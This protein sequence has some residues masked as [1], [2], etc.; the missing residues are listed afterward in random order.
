LARIDEV[1]EAMRREPA[2]VLVTGGGGFI[3]SNLAERLVELGQRV[4]VLDNFA[5]GH[6]RNVPAGVELVEGDIR[7]LETCQK[8]CEGVRYVF[9]QAALGSVP[10]S[11][12]DPLTSHQVNVDGTMNM[13]V[14]ARDARVAGF[15]YASSSSVYGDHP[16]LP[17]VE[18]VE[19]TPLSPYAVTKKV[20]EL[21]A[22]VFFD[23]YQLPVVGLRYFNVF[24]RRQDPN[25]AYAAVIPR[26]TGELL[27]GKQCVIFGDGETSRDFC[28]VEN[29]VQA[30]LLAAT[31]PREAHGQVFNV[32][33][34]ARTTLKDLFAMIRDELARLEPR[35]VGAQVKFEAFRPGDVRHSHANIEKA[36][37]LLGYEPTLS[38]QAGMGRTMAYYVENALPLPS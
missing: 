9:H 34:S 22:R 18:G 27:A 20:N 19:G 21:C 3:G 5:T 24:G 17:K 16:G 38:V 29:V 30:N 35:V 31:A 13:L 25:G 12:K 23:A 28:H 14:A 10:R 1:T 4:R 6:R 26:W 33:Y 36:R 15:V 11:L 2:Q 7:S 8:A 37:K 32:A